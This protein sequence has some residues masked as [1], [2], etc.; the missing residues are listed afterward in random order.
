MCVVVAPNKD[1][2]TF[3]TRNSRHH[4]LPTSNNTQPQKKLIIIFL[5]NYSAKEFKDLGR[6]ITKCFHTGTNCFNNKTRTKPS[7][8]LSDK[9]TWI[10]PIAVTVH[11]VQGSFYLCVDIITRCSKA[12]INQLRN[13]L[14]DYPA[15]YFTRSLYTQTEDH[16]YEHGIRHN[17]Q[18]FHGLW[19]WIFTAI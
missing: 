18:S 2:N 4:I 3:K 19:S 8:L 16:E 11:Y 13:C 9:L 15:W 12:L 17:V 1:P 7:T 10:Q 5:W 14:L 6:A